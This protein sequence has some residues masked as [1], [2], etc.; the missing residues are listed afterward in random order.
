MSKLWPFIHIKVEK[1][2]LS[3]PFVGSSPLS[4]AIRKVLFLTEAPKKVPEFYGDQRSLYI[5]V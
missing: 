4:K 2:T 5:F 3:P 1:K